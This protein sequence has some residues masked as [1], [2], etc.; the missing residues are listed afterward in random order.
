MR[1]SRK[2]ETIIII[3]ILLALSLPAQS[4]EIYRWVDSEGV[5]HYTD[6]P[7]EGI[8][9][10]KNLNVP[11]PDQQADTYIRKINRL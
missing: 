10:T 9:E 7:P 5:V 3:L 1:I 8:K 2:L 6:D 4:A 11:D